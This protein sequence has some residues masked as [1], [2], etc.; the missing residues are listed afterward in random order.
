[1][2]LM[3]IR[4]SPMMKMTMML[5][6]IKADVCDIDDVYSEYTSVGVGV[7]DNDDGS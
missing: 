1:M 6:M 5:I 2:S 7:D 4:L 3:L